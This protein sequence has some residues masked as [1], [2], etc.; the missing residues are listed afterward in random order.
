M[1]QAHL[2]ESSYN[3]YSGTQNKLRSIYKSYQ[4]V[5]VVTVRSLP[6]IPPNTV[7]KLCSKKTVCDQTT[8]LIRISSHGVIL[9]KIR[10]RHSIGIR[11]FFNFRHGNGTVSNRCK[12]KSTE[13]SIPAEV[14]R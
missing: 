1:S 2:R 3:Q 12:K 10:Q 6:P 5:V 11:S 7:E 8:A 14:E 4:I 13:V 9:D